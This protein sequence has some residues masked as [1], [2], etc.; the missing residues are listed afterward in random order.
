[1]GSGVQLKASL[2]RCIEREKGVENILIVRRWLFVLSQT[3]SRMDFKIYFATEALMAIVSTRDV[4]L[5]T[6]NDVN[7]TIEKNLFLFF[8][9]QAL[10]DRMSRQDLFAHMWDVALLV[11][12][13]FISTE[14]TVGPIIVL[15]EGLFTCFTP[16]IH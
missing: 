10:N 3:A 6:V 8:N 15:Y 12:Y 2:W 16:K 9:I 1:M 13:L 11:I 4:H 7:I 5:L 14:E